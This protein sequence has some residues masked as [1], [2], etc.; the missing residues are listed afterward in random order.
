M[1]PSNKYLSEAQKNFGFW[2]DKPLL[3]KIYRHFFSIIHENIDYDLPGKIVELGSGIANIRSV[4]ERCICTD[5]WPNPWID[6]VEDVYSLSF[7]NEAV[8]N[9]I[10]FDVFHHLE[11]PGD[12]LDEIYRVLCTNGRLIIF[13]PAMSLTGLIV[14]GL[15]HKEPLGIFKKINLYSKD[16]PEKNAVYYSAQA[17]ASRIINQKN[18]YGRL[19][20]KW[21]IA[22]EKKITSF[23]YL[24]SGGYSKR[25]AYP[26]SWLPAIMKADQYLNKFP[27]VF[28]ARK[29]IVMIKT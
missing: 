2:S 11:F 6:Q 9:I 25:Q 28:A 13:E 5:R 23:A 21:D 24:G 18:R 29:L 4:I 7:K 14:Y 16:S 19:L 26:D 15:F 17:N 10:L 22:V 27:S 8:S 12:A 20:G 1:A 3:Q